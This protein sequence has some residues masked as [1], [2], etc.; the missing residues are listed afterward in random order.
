[1]RSVSTLP[2]E[3]GANLPA[4]HDVKYTECHEPLIVHT[5]SCGLEVHAHKP[6]SPHALAD[7]QYLRQ[8]EGMR[9]SLRLP[10]QHKA[11]TSVLP[12]LQMAQNAEAAIAS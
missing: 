1:M 3:K 6:S 7:I 9:P 10:T 5:L 8:R 2:T 11:T 12:L 4:K